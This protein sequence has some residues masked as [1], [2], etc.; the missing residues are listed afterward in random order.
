ML[1]NAPPSR[2]IPASRK[3]FA[4]FRQAPYAPPIRP[5][6]PNS[7]TAAPTGVLDKP[8][9][10]L[11]GL[12]FFFGISLFMEILVLYFNL[13]FPVTALAWMAVTGL[14]LLSGNIREFA[15]SPV[16]LPWCALYAW[17]IL[18][19]VFG[20]YPRGSL[21]LMWEYGLRFHLFGFV[22]CALALTTQSIRI[23]IYWLTAGFTLVLFLCYR[24]GTVE[25]GRFLIPDLSFANANDL[26]F[27]LLLGAVLMLQLALNK[28]V[29]TRVIWLAIAPIT[30]YYLLLTGSRANFITLG[31][32]VITTLVV[33]SWR[34]RVQV[35]VCLAVVAVMLVGLLPRSTLYRLGTFTSV[36]VGDDVTDEDIMVAGAATASTQSRIALQWRAIG[37]T[38]R[39]PIFGVGPSN[40]AIAVEE[41]VQANFG[42]KSTWQVPHNS[43]LDVSSESGFPGFLLYAASIYLCLRMNY[44]CF[45]RT[46]GR[47]DQYKVHTQSFC[48]LLAVVVYAFGTLFCSIVY[49]FYCSFLVALSAAN[50]LALEREE[51]M[52]KTAK[53]KIP[54]AKIASKK[55]DGVR[56]APAP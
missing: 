24:Y 27:H 15:R 18:A 13:P 38:V 55:F 31:V 46:Q 8:G 5:T 44:Q 11:L 12:Y 35:L 39:N 2:A 6:L 53:T 32:V 25:N 7:V 49:N 43:Y 4:G 40:F 37:M 45:K 26:A 47:P 48:L 9:R 30:F 52:L 10:F 28:S 19:S 29:F 17:W 36:A 42:R 16:C 50:Y 33:V 22:V 20:A 14:A 51:R 34:Q 54:T 1:P 41:F 23:L 56:L 21:D 3:P